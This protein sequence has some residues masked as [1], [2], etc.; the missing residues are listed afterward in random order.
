[1]KSRKCS[2]FFYF[3]TLS[4]LKSLNCI[5][6]NHIMSRHFFI[7]LF[8]IIQ[9]TGQAQTVFPQNNF[10]SSS[11]K[12]Y[13]KNKLP[14]PGY[15]QQDVHYQIMATVDDSLDIIDGA[16]KLTYWNNSPFP[17]TEL[18]FHLI[19]NAF[20]PESYY[21]DLNKNNDIK[22][23]FGKYEKQGLGTQTENIK[24]NG[25]DV[26]TEL[27]NTV[28]NVLLNEPLKSGDSIVITM[29]FKTYFDSGSMRRRM[30]EFDTFGYKHFD[31]VQWYPAIAVY[32]HKFGWETEQH[33][34]KEFYGD[35]GTFDVALTFPQEYIVEATGDLVN[36]DMVM[37]A[38]LREK[39]DLKNFAK[40]PFNEAPSVIIPREK[41]KTKTWYFHAENV[42]NFA[43]TAD[44]LYRIGEVN[45]NGIRVIALAQEPHA[46]RW[47]ESAYYTARVI[48][49]YSEDFGMYNWPKIIVAD[50][51][52]GMEY[53]M[54]T[55]DGGT[56]PQHQSLLAHEVGHMWFYGM[57]GSN[58]IYRASLD[59]GFTQFLTVWSM[60]RILG[61][62]R[63]RLAKSEYIT[64]HLDS[65][66]TRYEN[67]Y[68]PYLNHVQEGYDEPLNTHSSGFNG[69]IRHG[70]NYGL[71]YYKTGTMLYNLRYVLGDELFINAMRYYVRKWKFAHPYPEDFRESIIEYTQT[72]LN[73]FFDQW[74][75]TTKYI[76]YS[77]DDISKVKENNQPFN[78]EIKFS[79]KG[80]M[81][82]PI[83][84][85]VTTDDGKQYQYYIPNTWF[86]KQT[87]A[88]VLPKWYGWDLL[89]PTYTAR[90]NV[91]GKIKTVEI[92]PARYLAD[93]DLTNNKKGAGGISTW[94][95][96]HRIPNLTTWATQKNFWRPDIWYNWY[97]GI[98]IGGHIEG[99]YM[100]KN[101]Y[102]AN[103]WYNTRL[104]QV[105]IPTSEKT[106]NQP[107]AFD[108]YNKNILNKLWRGTT[109][110]Q[111]AYYNAGIWKFNLGLEK[112]FR[113]QDSRNPKYSKIFI[114]TKYL[115][116]DISY[117]NYLLYPE[118]WGKPAQQDNFV[119]ASIN[120]GFFRNYTYSKGTGEF[121][122]SL[123]TPSFGSDYNYAYTNLVSLNRITWK[124]F[125][126]KSRVFA[127]YGLGDF[128]LESQLFL[129]G[130]NPEQ[131]MDNKY[132]RA[133]AFVPQ[134]WL[135]YGINSNHFQMGGGLNLRAYSGYLTAE[136]IKV[137]GNDSIA[138]AYAGKSGA[139]YNLEVD[140][141]RFI[142]FT[143][144]LFRN[145]KLDTYLFTDLGILNYTTAGNKNIFGKF[146][147]DAGIGTALT[148]K[149]GSYD[150]K[151][152]TI[153]FDMPFFVNAAP[154]VSDYLDFRYVLG[155]NRA[156]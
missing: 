46:A 85:T 103:V 18:Y 72:D 6:Y 131:L 54:L 28:L 151:P 77:V 108:I 63:Q 91:P 3:V 117:Q 45:W 144:K 92:D 83:D 145:L 76:D 156:F 97:D 2:G 32:D 93:M 70:G 152:L 35:F 8:L 100:N 106:K 82:M 88:K 155:I 105:E 1:M 37:P 33:L 99:S 4:D 121:T 66:D 109:A 5:D 20:Q 34:D 13:W 149:F 102:Y 64:K 125:E 118:Q 128:P 79:R 123:R 150:I 90:I 114:S 143:P 81:H 135:G 16:Y 122:I 27:D 49:V 95:F 141:D 140:F 69:A 30:K 21:D 111:Q 25:R 74:L 19:Q 53:P 96:D 36:K 40:K 80:R 52:D 26:Q 115:I 61:E 31:G 116:N 42:H 127:Q 112:T 43:F 75:E 47:Q 101:S 119:N 89:E 7:L 126:I 104:G 86:I 67:L 24:V 133:K 94:E 62:K 10:R 130:A 124:K 57:I 55:L 71:V 38:D 50:A 22:V 134:D 107:V 12:L 60:D 84:F 9:V 154:A 68:Y 15:W 138:F 39:L 139:S 73:W 11:N 87:D 65:S 113:K 29:D 153:R 129:A 132:T 136:K 44:P 17:L 23:K 110:Y 120:M 142:K 48:Q 147:M 56:Y 137:N 14:H 51:K 41:G 58:E 146:R 148:V 78:Y 98:Q 59:E